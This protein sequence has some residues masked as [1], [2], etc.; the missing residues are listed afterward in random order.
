V[1]E[2]ITKLKCNENPDSYILCLKILSKLLKMSNNSN[3][4]KAAGRLGNLDIDIIGE[5]VNCLNGISLHVGHLSDHSKEV[6]YS[7]VKNLIKIIKGN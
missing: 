5:Y 2:V 4:Q 6:Y 3:N 7:E 1:R